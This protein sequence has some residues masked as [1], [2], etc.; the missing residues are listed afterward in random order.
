MVKPSNNSA[1]CEHLPHCN[2]LPSFHNFS[3]L[4]HENKKYLLKIKEILLIMR[5]KPL[6]NRNVNS[7]PFIPV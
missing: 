7:A 6:L 4:A 1:V 3:I 2:Y 5:D